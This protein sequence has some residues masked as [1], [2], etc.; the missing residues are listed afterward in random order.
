VTPRERRE[1]TEVRRQLAAHYW[2]AHE[3]LEQGQAGV[4]EEELEA[5][6]VLQEAEANANVRILVGAV[7]RKIRKRTR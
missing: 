6:R 4:A 3:A 7:E 5:M 2:R 1:E